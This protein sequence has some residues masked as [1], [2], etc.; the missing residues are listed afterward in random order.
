M[1]EDTLIRVCEERDELRAEV[2]R[3][4][5]ALKAA[6]KQR[7][8]FDLERR[9]AGDARMAAEARVRELE[10][11]QAK[12]LG[13]ADFFQGEHR[14]ALDETFAVC[15]RL[16]TAHALLD[17]CDS[18]GTLPRELKRKI[19]AHLAAQPATAPTAV[20][21]GKALEAMGAAAVMALVFDDAAPIRTEVED[22]DL[23]AGGRG[24]SLEEVRA[25]Y[26]AAPART[27]AL[28]KLIN[29]SAPTP[30]DDR[31]HVR[32]EA[33]QAVLDAMGKI[34]EVLLR[35]MLEQSNTEPKVKPAIVAEL[36][37]RGLK[38]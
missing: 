10:A 30:W 2:A 25:T 37:R 29:A 5:E 3:L 34:P 26:P 27:E 21:R 7:D 15:Q 35:W 13:R 11:D 36:A 9:D 32:L 8:G 6:E 16:A 24:L 33:E 22:F 17:R 4:R 28:G 19:A 1:S 18:E 38:P 12:V 20:E 14:K 23:Q 31:E